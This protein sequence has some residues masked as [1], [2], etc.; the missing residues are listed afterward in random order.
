LQIRADCLAR[1]SWRRNRRAAHEGLTK[2]ACRD[3]YPILQKEGVLLASALLESPGSFEKLFQRTAASSTLSIL[4]DYPTLETDNDK[5]L[6]G[7]HAFIE[8][9]SVAA[10]P[11]TYLVELMPWMMHIPERSV[12]IFIGC[13]LG[14]VFRMALR[15]IRKVE[16]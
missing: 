15:Q 4:Y 1:T 9:M 6:K 10:A 8:R 3:Y 14:S 13:F 7:I 2:S 16:V 12:H 5:T 11:G